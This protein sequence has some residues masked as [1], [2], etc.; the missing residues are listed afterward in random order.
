VLVDACGQP[1]FGIV[2][3]VQLARDPDELLRW[4]L[5]AVMAKP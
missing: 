2:V 3:E 5:Y 1:A 4:P